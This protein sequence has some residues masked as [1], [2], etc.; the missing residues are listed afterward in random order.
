MHPIFEVIGQQCIQALMTFYSA[1]ALEFIGNGGDLEVRFSG[2]TAVFVALIDDL[3]MLEND[4]LAQA[5]LDG[6]L[7]FH[8]FLTGK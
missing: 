6:S 1:H 7:N 4:R 3:E 2:G 5:L 8:V